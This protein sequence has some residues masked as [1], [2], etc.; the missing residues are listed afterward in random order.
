MRAKV[1]DDEFH[2]C[3]AA[4]FDDVW[5]FARRRCRSADVADDL[6][7]ETFAVAWRRRADLPEGHEARLWLFGAARKVLANHER[8]ERRRWQL[9][10]R[11]E[12]LWS[13]PAAEDRDEGGALRAALAALRPA[14][15]DLLVM[16]AWDELPVRD[17]AVLLGVT[18]NAV[19]IR[20]HKAR[21]RLAAA[22]PK[23]AVGSRTGTGRS[24]L[25]EGEV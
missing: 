8:G 7:A 4:H 22:L 25:M 16:A 21:K 3:F 24:R 9:V 20:L 23:D 1:E 6:T 13:P 2:A 14:D 5:R 19:S 18:P 10:E 15:R 11:L 17:I 12:A